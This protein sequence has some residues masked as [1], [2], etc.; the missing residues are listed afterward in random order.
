MIAPHQLISPHYLELQK[1]LHQAPQGYGGRGDKWAGIVMQ[2]AV[3]YDA[4]SILDYGCGEGSLATVLRRSALHGIRIDE[5][6]PAIPGKDSRPGFAD[7][8]VCTD[9]LEH[10]EPDRLDNV[11]ADLRML[12]RKVL[13]V[14]VST[15]DSNKVLAD[16][17]NA[18]LI[19]E[20]G[21]WWKQKVRAAGFTLHSAPSV[22]RTV[23]RKEWA[24]VLTP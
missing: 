16:G 15:K 7:L 24:V 23:P 14:V 22:V 17:R 19:I 21:D 10:I 9:V 18:H 20:N 8:V 11:L 1:R 5:Y 2:L 6:D 4:W 3:Q 13:W 12:A